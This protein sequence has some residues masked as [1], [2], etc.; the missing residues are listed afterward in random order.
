MILSDLCPGFQG[1]I[2]EV[3]YWKTARLKNK[4]TIAKEET[5]PNIRNGTMFSD[6]Y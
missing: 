2:F 4:V 6:L 3:E 5:V 1:H